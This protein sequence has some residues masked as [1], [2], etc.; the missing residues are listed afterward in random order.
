[1]LPA[2]ADAIERAGD[3]TAEVDELE[4]TDKGLQIMYRAW[5]ELGNGRHKPLGEAYTRCPMNTW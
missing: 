2:I 4:I 3:G 5:S 1:L